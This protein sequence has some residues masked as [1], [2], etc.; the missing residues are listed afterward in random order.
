MVKKLDDLITDFLEYLELEKGRSELTVRN[1][2]HYLNRFLKFAGKI[3]PSEIDLEK[4]KEY[5]LHL[6]RLKD[7]HGQLLKKKTQNYHLIALRA[8]LRYLARIDILAISPEK[9]DLAEEEDREIAFL[10]PDELEALFK[11]TEQEKKKLIR[12]RDKAI[13]ET[14]FSTG[15]RVSELVKLKTEDVNLDRGEFNVIGKGKK[16]RI[17]FLSDEAKLAIENYLNARK[18]NSPALFFRHSG[19]PK[20]LEEME[21]EESFLTPRTIQRVIVKYASLAGITKKVTPHVLRHSFATDM[22]RS[23]ADLRSVQA[24]LGHSNVT[25]TQ[26]YTHITNPHLKEMHQKFHGKTLKE[27]EE[28]A[29]IEMIKHQGDEITEFQGETPDV[30]GSSRSDSKISKADDRS[31]TAGSIPD[32]GDSS[33]VRKSSSLESVSDAGDQ[34]SA[35]SADFSS[36]VQKSRTKKS[37]KQSALKDEVDLG[38]I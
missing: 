33:T 21:D 18:D 16:S 32:A 10:E 30:E 27:A 29:K 14:L 11:S 19:N 1:Y 22:L 31:L 15:L 24:M 38:E 2:E 35:K 20:I 23:G 36:R 28:K 34:R 8:F 7:N 25:T 4:I 6:N 9:I 5:R 26:V 17:V 12:L 3:S 37:K 13:L